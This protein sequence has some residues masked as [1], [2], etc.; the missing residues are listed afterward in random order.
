MR[1]NVQI[2][3]KVQQYFVRFVI[4][5]MYRGINKNKKGDEKMTKENEYEEIKDAD[6]FRFEE[7]GDKIEGM[8]TDKGVSQKYNFGIYT[9]MSKDGEQKRFHGTTQ[10][11]QL[12]STI[13]LQDYIIIEYVDNEKTPAGAMK[14]FKIL[15]KK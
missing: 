7:I 8:L 11:D 1:P 3:I 4:A 13:E 12:M 15:R 5:K 14:L 2:K 9:I 10:L 6:F